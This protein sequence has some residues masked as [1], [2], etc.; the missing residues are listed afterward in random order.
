[1]LPVHLSVVL[2]LLIVLV[3]QTIGISDIVCMMLSLCTSL[4]YH[5]MPVLSVYYGLSGF[6]G[7]NLHLWIKTELDHPLYNQWQ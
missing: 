4:H 2:L 1:M 3:D 6:L 7:S 5:R